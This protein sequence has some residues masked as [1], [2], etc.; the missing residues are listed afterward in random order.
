MYVKGE[1]NDRMLA[2]PALVS[3]FVVSKDVD[4]E[5]ARKSGRYLIS[6]FGMKLGTERTLSNMVKARDRG[7]LTTEY[8]GIEVVEE[9]GFRSC[10]KF[11][12]SKYDPPEEE[13]VYELTF[14]IDVET[15]LQSGSVLKDVKGE[16]IAE[17]FFRDIKL[18]P[19]FGP[20]QFTRK[21]M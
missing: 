20:N 7:K 9:L 4:C 15:W 17:Y 13:G 5:D 18:N 12:R 3:F 1:N 6:Q 8:H 10:F 11:V 21:A 14:Y 19:Q 2:L 16:T